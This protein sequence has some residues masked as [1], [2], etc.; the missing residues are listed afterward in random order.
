MIKE[1]TTTITETGLKLAMRTP[2]QYQG[3]EYCWPET[4]LSTFF[5]FYHRLREYNTASTTVK[6]RMQINN[7]DVSIFSYWQTPVKIQNKEDRT[8]LLK[9]AMELFSL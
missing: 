8:P 6:M 5:S 7:F 1:D 2:K 3:P 4:N 9:F